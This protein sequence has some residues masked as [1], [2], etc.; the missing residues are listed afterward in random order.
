MRPSL[1]LACVFQCL[2]GM[3]QSQTHSQTFAFDQGGGLQ[4][5]L[6]SL[7]LGAGKLTKRFPHCPPLRLFPLPS[8]NPQS[9]QLLYLACISRCSVFSGS[10]Y[11]LLFSGFAFR[12]SRTFTSS[13]TPTSALT[14]TLT[15]SATCSMASRLWRLAGPEKKGNPPEIMYGR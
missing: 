1:F 12:G 10:R 7:V 13:D 14:W 2:L 4:E 5:D 9:S 3:P 8:K 11:C 15:A 6:R